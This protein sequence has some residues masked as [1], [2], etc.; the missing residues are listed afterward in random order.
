MGRR[1]AHP[2]IVPWLSSK[3]DNRER[4]FIQL[5]N[6]LLLSRQFHALGAGSRHLYCRMAMERGGRRTFLFPQAAAK[7]YSIAPSSLRKHISELERARKPG[8]REAE[9][10]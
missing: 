10:L 9:K 4:R 2:T 1:K 5:G 8:R 3:A 6:S 7:K